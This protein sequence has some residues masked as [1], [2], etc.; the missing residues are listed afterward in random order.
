MAA[1]SDMLH[2]DEHPDAAW[3][4]GKPTGFAFFLWAFS[5]FAAQVGA[6]HAL[7]FAREVGREIGREVG[8]GE[9]AFSS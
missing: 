8:N 4:R 7:R 2:P 3:C 5:L 6:F 1:P 9:N